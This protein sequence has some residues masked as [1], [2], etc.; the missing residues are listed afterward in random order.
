MAH[1]P[2]PAPPSVPTATGQTK[3]LRRAVTLKTKDRKVF[4][5][6]DRLAP[7]LAILVS[8]LTK[9]P[10]HDQQFE[11]VDQV[12]DIRIVE[13]RRSHRVG[14]GWGL[15]EI[16]LDFTGERVRLRIAVEKLSS[17]LISLIETVID[18]RRP[19]SALIANAKLRALLAYHTFCRGVEVR[20]AEEVDEDS[21]ED[22][23]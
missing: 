2:P 18:A 13:G 11:T 16:R 20:V 8:L 14:E 5:E 7:I 15:D 12:D 6:V 10:S 22:R 21:S 4:R 9:K 23:E 19:D 3:C 17:S 1:P